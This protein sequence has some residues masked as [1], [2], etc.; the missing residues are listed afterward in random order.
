M[1][2]TERQLVSSRPV[3]DLQS[4]AESQQCQNVREI[5]S[6]EYTNMKWGKRNLRE[7]FKKIRDAYKR[8]V[9]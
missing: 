9:F 6:E 1:I 3:N 4:T 2:I 7:V 5:V 8:N